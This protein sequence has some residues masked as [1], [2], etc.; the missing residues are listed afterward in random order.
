MSKVDLNARIPNNVGLGEDRRLQRALEAWQPGFQRVV[1]RHGPR[2]L[3]GRPDLPAHGR[4]RRPRRLGALRAREDARLP[5]GHLPLRRG[6]RPPRPLRRPRRPARLPAGARRAP[7][8]AAPHHRDPGR[9]GARQ[10]RAAAPARPHAPPASTTCAT[11]SRSTSRRAAT[12]GPWSTCCTPTSAATGARRPRTCS[13]AARAIADSPRIL[14]HVQRA[15]R[16]L[17]VL[18][19][20]H[21]VHGPGRQVAAPRPGRVGLRPP[22]AHDA[23]HADGGGAPHVRRRDGRR[24]R[25]PAHAPRS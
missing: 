22:L 9:H 24:P 5:L 20:V 19:H 17:A 18:L 16:G 6:R 23:L 12:S 10:R 25:R 1:A 14:G 3:P 11:S 7:Q 2:G 4:R 8:R 21:H 13:A 15:D